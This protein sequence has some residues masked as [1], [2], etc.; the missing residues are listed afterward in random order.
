MA[1][2]HK[3]DTR[4]D[5]E[6]TVRSHA[7]PR[8]EHVE[9]NS[10]HNTPGKQRST[11]ESSE[12]QYRETPERRER[13]E[14]REKRTSRQTPDQ[15]P[16]HRRRS[17]ERRRRQDPTT[18]TS[19]EKSSNPLSLDS[20]AK[21]DAYNEKQSRRPQENERL[22]AAKEKDRGHERRQKGRV[23]S[24]RVVKD[25]SRHRRHTEHNRE[26]R[27][28][29]SGPLAEEG[30]V[31]KRGGYI[32]EDNGKKRFGRKF[33]LFVISVV[34]LLVILIPVGVYVSRKHGG[35]K[36]SSGGGSSDDGADPANENLK[37]VDENDIPS[38]AK[39]TYLDPFT[40]YDTTD[41]NVT[42]TDET[43]GGLS[44]MG[45]NTA[46]DDGTQANENVPPLNKEWI[47]GTMP[48]RGV[49]IGGWLSIEPFITPSLFKSYKSNQG[50]IDEYTL[51]KELGPQKAAKM[52]EKHYAKFIQ[53]DDFKQIQAAGFDHVRISYAYWAVTTYPGDPYVPKT[54]WRYLLRA[55]EYCRKYGLRVNLDLHALPGS[56]NGWN[57]SGRQGAIGWLNGTDGDSNAQRSLDIHTQLSTFFA[58][59]RYKNVIAI[60]GLANEPKMIAL[61]TSV[62]LD[63]ETKAAAIVRKSGMQQ[64]L[65][66]GDG[67]LGLS[68]WKGQLSGVQNV[69]L[70]V[71]Q[72]T[73]F[74]KNQI[75]FSHQKK[76][77]YACQG[78]TDQMKQSNNAITGFGPTICG[79]WSQADTDC[80]VFLNNVNTGSR[81]EGTLPT[82][83]PTTSVTTPHCPPNS[84][85]CSCEK[86][87]AD[88]SAYSDEYKQWLMMYAEAQM[89]SFE[90]GWG[91]FYWTWVT[92]SA[93]QWSWKAGMA[94]G[95]LPKKTWQ[96]DFNCT[97]DIPDFADLPET[98]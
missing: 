35:G 2:P 40:W 78:W 81:W 87:N 94:A 72:Y 15:S 10:P 6:R 46:W 7:R 19:S 50:I 88:P 97:A 49:N 86:A 42:Y 31:R 98:Y 5:P 63:W 33:W 41:F 57:H 96:R 24:G 30:Y 55:I 75:N 83:D 76:I 92:E 14:G 52:L 39:N 48:I 65:V 70:D 32:A 12:R 66:V 9:R 38:T 67:F 8:R 36:D 89:A 84:G 3:R 90:T 60:Y 77:Q 43:V 61:P 69:I 21:L 1:G 68:K 58:Q 29:I 18:Y 20:L 26:K 82:S 51:T 4:Q 93:P 13:R 23:V 53:E 37:G 56:Q 79:E 95:T 34:L 16:Q 22:L 64:Y 17:P 59:P 54:S 62:V 25:K 28:V 45:L 80:A 73:I 47:Y 74:N 71:H 27:R 91:W 44:V 85:T 11:N